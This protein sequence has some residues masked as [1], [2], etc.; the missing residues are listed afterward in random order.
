MAILFSGVEQFVQFHEGH[1]CEIILNLSQW[2]RRRSPLKI[3]LFYALVPNLFNG[4]LCNLG[5]GHYWKHPYEIILNLVR[6]F[7]SR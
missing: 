6:W 5:R 1:L 2:F 7:K 4:A 3:F